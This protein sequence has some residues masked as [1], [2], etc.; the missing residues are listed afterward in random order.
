MNAIQYDAVVVGGGVVGATTAIALHQA[1]LSTAMVERGKKPR[2]FDPSSYDMRVYA[3]SPGSQE[4]LTRLGI[5]AGIAALRASVFRSVHV[6]V[7]RP[8]AGLK[9]SAADVGRGELGWIVEHGVL[10]DRLWNGLG[11]VDLYVSSEIGEVAF[12]NGSYCSQVS[13]A[14]GPTLQSALLIGADGA[15]SGLRER[16]GIDTVGRR[17]PQ[18]AIVCHV[19]TTRPHLQTA[20][21]RFLPSGPLA[22][23]PLADGRSSIVWSVNPSLADDLTG[24]DD[25]EFCRRLNDAVD[26]IFGDILEASPRI[27]VPLREQQARTYVK[28]GLALIGDAAH[29]MHPLAGQGVN[30]G[31]ADV[32][33][34]V[35]TVAEARLAGRNWASARTL[36][37]YERARRTE[38]TEML[39][40]TDSLYRLFDSRFPGL[41]T[42]LG[43]G[44]DG[45]NLLSPVREWL[46]SRAVGA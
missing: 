18:R 2:S 8:D 31:L 44:M 35:D 34:L 17:Y 20:W 42:A 7:D 6:W 32:A 22:F 25:H 10:L 4:T 9:F 23:L 19:H 36:R 27:A 3:I 1:G 29:A 15:D 13:L 41:R 46:A 21:Q 12:G 30:M 24:L 26:G 43:I 37:R 28:D 5:W 38:N 33:V 14:N 40:V 11:G 39:M 16:A 45:I